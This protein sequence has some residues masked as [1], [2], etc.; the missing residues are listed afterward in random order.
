VDGTVERRG[1]RL[2]VNLSLIDGASAAE[3]DRETVERPM[4]D[5]FAL[6]EEL[7]NEVGALLG[8]M[9]E[10]EIDLRQARGG[11]ESVAAWTLFQRGE[12]EREEGERALRE[13]DIDAFARGFRTAD[14]LYSEAE[15]ADPDWAPPLIQRAGLSELLAQVA[16]G[17]GPDQTISWLNAGVQYADRAL[18]LDQR[19]ADAL[20]VRGRLEYLRWRMGLASNPREADRAFQQALADLEQAT[21]LDS[22]LAEAWNI[23]SIVYSEEA[24]NTEAKLAA[25]RAYE[26]DEFSRVADQVLFHLYATSYDLEQFR[27]ATE[28]CDEGRGRFPENP[29]FW[30]CRLWLLAAPSSQAPDPDPEEAWAT[31]EEFVTRIPEQ[32]REYQ[33]LKGQLL[34]AGALARAELRD[35]A[36]AVLARSQATPELDPELEI[37]GWEAL[38]RLQMGQREQALDL[39]RAYLT[40]NPQHREGWQWTAHWWWRPLQEDPEFRALMEG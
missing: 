28:Y 3:I 17:E 40:T 39:L 20:F 26:A 34:V 32:G 16:I 11:T 9:L 33:R 36:E 27:D 31:L 18:S 25:R 8:R 5:L 1:D 7:A 14:S 12:R 24:N 35:S 21:R 29:R 38:I 2:R 22:S 13:G 19:D 10:E 37:K 6:Q 15:R 4:D 23:L 30:E